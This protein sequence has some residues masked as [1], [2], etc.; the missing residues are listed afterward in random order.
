M[1]PRD[2]GGKALRQGCR[3]E[4]GDEVRSVGSVK[5][6]RP[7]AFQCQ[8]VGAEMTPVHQSQT[9]NQAFIGK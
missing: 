1:S 2:E 4:W 7:V 9:R 5:R 3:D 6:I 8:R